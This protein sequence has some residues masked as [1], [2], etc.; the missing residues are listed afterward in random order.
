MNLSFSR[1]SLRRVLLAFTLGGLSACAVLRPAGY[2]AFHSAVAQGD[3]I[4]IYDTL[5][6]L[7]A[8]DNDTSADRKAAFKA[9]RNRNEDTAEFQFAWAAVAGRLVQRRGLLAL[10]LVKDIE[11]HALRSRELDPD[12][13]DG[14]ATRLLGT[15][16]VVAPSSFLEHGNSELGLEMLEDLVARHPEDPIITCVRPRLTSP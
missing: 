1:A 11:K 16:Y 10:D 4:R 12:F 3:A 6:A 14:D 5:E 9:L 13:R 8:E 2:E 15:L 7:I